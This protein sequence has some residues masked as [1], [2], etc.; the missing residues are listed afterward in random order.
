MISRE[1]NIENVNFWEIEMGDI[2]YLCKLRGEDM[3]ECEKLTNNLA[4]DEFGN[5]HYMFSDKIVVKEKV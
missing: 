2:F 4:E 5:I 3:I 1:K